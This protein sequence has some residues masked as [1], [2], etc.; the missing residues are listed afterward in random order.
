MK[1]GIR[2]PSLK[3]SLSA[4]SPLTQLKRK[5]SITKYTHPI[6]TQK[7][8]VYN[9]IYNATTFDVTPN[10]ST[11]V[12]LNGSSK[13]TNTKNNNSHIHTST[14]SHTTNCN[15]SHFPYE[16]YYT[17]ITK[18][19]IICPYCGGDTILV[20]NTFV[21]CFIYILFILGG[22]LFLSLGNF[23]LGGLCLFFGIG[24]LNYESKNNTHKCK[25]CNRVSNTKK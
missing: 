25:K 24:G 10:L 17:E 23:I 1:H 12:I 9:K 4:R 5:T 14:V 19:G 16:N 15:H 13:S 18:K 6:K 22:G 8:K 3:K 11:K 20:K 7:K 21:V 2:K